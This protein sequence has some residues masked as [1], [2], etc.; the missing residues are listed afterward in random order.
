MEKIRVLLIEDNP[1]DARLVKEMLDESRD[2]RFGLECFSSLSSGLTRIKESRPDVVLLDLSLPDCRGRETLATARAEAPEMPLVILTGL[3]DERLGLKLVK[4][5]AQ[6]Y[7]VKGEFDSRLLSRSLYYSIER[8]RAE[9]LAAA[10]DA[11]LEASRLKSL[12]LANMSHE[13]RT[14]MNAVIGMT[15]LLLDTQLSSKQ[16]ELTDT[17]WSS[18]KALLEIINDIL[19]FSKIAS[20]K[21]IFQEIDVDVAEVTAS[22]MALFAEQVQAK[23]LAVASHIDADVPRLMRG[24]PGRLRQVLVNLIGNA[25]KFTDSGEVIVTVD[26]ETETDERIVLRFVVTDTGSGIPDEALHRLFQPFSQADSSTTRKYG[27]TGLGLAIS[28]QLVEGMGGRIGVDS[29]PGKGSRFWFTVNLRK[30][31]LRAPSALSEKTQS[32][33]DAEIQNVSKLSMY[34]FAEGKPLHEPQLQSLLAQPADQNIS[35]LVVEDNPANQKVALWMLETLGYRAD[36]VH[37]GLEAVEAVSRTSYGAVLMDCQ[38]PEMDGYEATRRIRAAEGGSC[39]VTIIGMT[40]NALQGDREICL[41]AGMDDYIGKP[42]IIEDLAALLKK[43]TA[44]ESANGR[45]DTRTLL[46]AGPL[47]ASLKSNAEILDAELLETFR[48]VKVLG[49]PNLLCQLIDIFLADLP[50]RLSAMKISLA[51]GDAGLFREAAHALK[52]GCGSVGAKRMLALCAELEA[53][54]RNGGLDGA[55][56]ILQDLE[57]QA[58]RIRLAFQVEKAATPAISN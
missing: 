12:F 8:K 21:L 58:E 5:G 26:R 10:R 2:L 32:T 27:G 57:D 49:A 41:A 25:I 11:A 28:A 51:A 23:K 39:H 55:L 30:Q 36:L 47:D 45:V 7:L 3:D 35:I 9:K 50:L 4:E 29:S 48:R 16:R 53:T 31:Q 34:P 43:W 38:M 22:A 42:V 19:D 13:I 1:G 56:P 18:A 14:P 33:K 44:L 17:I 37:N 15:R 46:K 54:A 24:D 20:G 40:A 52:G 6:D